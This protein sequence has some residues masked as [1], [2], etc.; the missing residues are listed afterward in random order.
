MN[1]GMGLHSTGR[2]GRGGYG[3]VL[4]IGM[5]GATELGKGSPVRP[6]EFVSSA[7]ICGEAVTVMSSVR[8]GYELEVIWYQK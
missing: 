5:E 6:R 8:H 4:S 1:G 7:D 2:K 3:L